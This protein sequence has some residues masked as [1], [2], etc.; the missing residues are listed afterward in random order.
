MPGDEILPLHK[1]SSNCEP[2][3]NNYHKPKL[4]RSMQLNTLRSTI[5]DHK[6]SSMGKQVTKSSNIF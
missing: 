6:F 4:Y 3:H 5:F 2:L 1:K